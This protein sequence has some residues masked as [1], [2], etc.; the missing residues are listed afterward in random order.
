MAT[1]YDRVRYRSI[2]YPHTHPAHLAALATAHG[3]APPDPDRARILEIGCGG[4]GNLLPLAASL[5]GATVWGVD[6]AVTEIERARAEADALGLSNLA[7]AAVGVEAVPAGPPFDFVVAHGVLSWIP[8]TAQD[9]LWAL[10]RDRT[11]PG[12]VVVLSFN[13]YPGWTTRGAVRALMRWGS[14]AAPDPGARVAAARAVL[15]ELVAETPED[16]LWGAVLRSEQRVVDRVDDWYLFHDH[17]SEH[18][19]PFWFAEVAERAAAAGLSYVCDAEPD[20]A[21]CPSPA[22]AARSAD[23][24]D[25]AQAGDFARMTTFRSAVFARDPG[26]VAGAP[27][28]EALGRLTFHARAR[29]EQTDPLRLRTAAGSTVTVTDPAGEAVVRRLLLGTPADVPWSALR[30]V[31][32]DEGRLGAI[33]LQLWL[34]SEAIGARLGGTSPVR[35][36]GARPEVWAFARR[37]LAGGAAPVGPR[38]EAAPVGPL[39]AELAPL[40]DGTRDGPSLRAALRGSPSPEAL[41]R[42]LLELA[43]AGLLVR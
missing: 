11:A 9:A 25:A 13:T 4:G 16:S 29:I 26:V 1:D 36:P 27:R 37:A 42:A 39:A 15:A 31:V 21:L 19:T 10:L 40:L 5:P 2:P 32:P 24:L 6:P 38:L 18:N 7:L 34:G 23:A 17:L 41:T 35:T 3:G 8:P 43:A 33:L 30:E 20:R 28:P 12:A 22:L 14:R